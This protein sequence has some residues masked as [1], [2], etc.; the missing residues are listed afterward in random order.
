MTPH[1]HGLREQEV[2]EFVA[3]LARFRATLAL[4][5]E[6]L[7]VALLLAAAGERSDVQGYGVVRHAPCAA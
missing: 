7:F 4:Y 6:H 2:Q 1:P 3:Q 5:E